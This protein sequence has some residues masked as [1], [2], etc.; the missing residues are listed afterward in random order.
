[1]RM[2][3][4]FCDESEDELLRFAACLEEHFPHSMAKAVLKAA[5]EKGLDQNII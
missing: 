1:M 2:I 5:Q 4:P 3:V